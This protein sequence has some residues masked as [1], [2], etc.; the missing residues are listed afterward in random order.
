L[1]VACLASGPAVADETLTPEQAFLKQNCIE[2][3]NST[4]QSAAALYAGLFFDKV[5]V[6]HVADDP[7]TWEKVVR[8]LGAGMM[9]PAVKPR[10]DPVAKAEFLNY[11]ETELDAL[12][13]REPNPGRPALHRVNRTEYANAIRDLLGITV[14][15]TAMLPADDSTF[16]FDNIAGSLGVS[17]VLLERYVSAAGK[18]SRLAIGDTTMPDRQEKYVVPGDLTQTERI[19]GLPFGTRGG[20]LV[21]HY[22][23]VDAEYVIRADLVER[24]GRMFGSNTG[25]KERLEITLDDRLIALEDLAEYEVE[26]GVAVRLPVSAG[27]HTLAATFIKK[28]HAPVEDINQP[29]EF[30]LF[31]PAIDPDPRYTFVPHLASVAI[32]GPFNIGGAGD[33]PARE[34]I[35]VCR[36][37]KPSEEQPCARR[38]IETLATRA[39]R[40]PVEREQLST[41]MD[42][43]AQGRE[44]GGFE[45]GI[46]LALRRIL[47]SPEFVFRFERVDPKLAPGDI[48]RVDDLELASRL[49]FFLWS[50]IPDDE[51]LAVATSNRLHEP[52]TLRKQVERMLGDPRSQAF[53]ENFAG[54]WLYLR[55]LE[56]KG[57]AVEEFP[58]FDDNLRQAF[59]T[60]TEM[61]FASVVRENR[62]LLDILTADYTFVNERLARHY[63]IEG[64]YGSEFR[65]VP[66]T[67]EA[68]RG[69]LGHGSILMVTSYPN[70]TSPVQRGVWVLENIVGAPIPTP[71]P[72]VP[73]LEESAGPK[74]QPRTLR[75]QMELHRSKPFCEG[76]HKIMDPVGLALEN[77]DAIGRWRTEEHGEPINTKARLV[78]GTEIDG[79][80]DLRKALLKY[81]DRFV[82]T[83][84][85]KL[86]TYAL[87]R[88][89][90]YYDMPVVR[91]ITRGAANN[92]YRFD[93]L[94]M[95]IVASEP[96]RMRAV[97]TAPGAT[98]IVAGNH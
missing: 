80:V 16:G 58:D 52:P 40:R 79:V 89:L 41:L 87:G 26:D 54:Q 50:S 14:D 75:A 61:L 24:G 37:A 74:N 63:G 25:K 77:F 11:L 35:F 68:R 85:E 93:D 73:A 3:H 34:K 36:P 60:E 64:V 56:V 20:M 38:I 47:A 45:S 15:A 51:L 62:S 70:R 86:L 83:T 65:R 19:E 2:C 30:S 43:Y 23:P 27:P 94:I 76:C 55:N 29:F 72:N 95:G 59:R 49:S 46:E 1:A 42:F 17:P 97:E 28:N 33:T 22:F 90:E 9:P 18:I 82:Q 96:F 92:D 44:Q 66:V 8:K 5:D 31:E 78:D 81:S 12:A 32:T 7:E 91:E 57:G 10:P 69:I 4:D 13:A 98:E 6:T 84:V 48:Y 53:I 39:Y 67:D 71:P 88:G 21:T